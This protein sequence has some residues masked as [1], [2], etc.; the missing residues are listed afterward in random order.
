MTKKVIAVI[1]ARMASSRYPGKPLALIAGL[2]MIE[3]VRRRTLL[4]SVIDEAVVATCDQEIMDVVI[5]YGGQAIM[6]ADT[7]ER[8]TTRVDEAMH[9]L[10]GEI[11]VIVQG[12]EPLIMPD[13]IEQT[14]LPIQNRD[15]VNCTN[16]LSKITSP[17]DF[18]DTNI[19]KAALDKLGFIMYFSRASIPYFKHKTVCPIYR[20]TGIMAFTT[21]LLHEYT[22]LSETP[23]ERAES[24]DMFRLL[25]HA[26]KVLGVPTDHVTIGVDHPED[27]DKVEHLLINDSVQQSL[28]QQIIKGIQ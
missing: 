20:Q 28:H 18:N 14:V 8:C 15:N 17:A 10:T 6:T 12:D 23:F 5:G 25:E 19:V 1:P 3:Y 11:V 13:A 16:L 7:H 27:V 21:P 24:I 26:H 22:Q 4:C 2:P 9:N